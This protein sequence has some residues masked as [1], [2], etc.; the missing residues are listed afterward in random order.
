MP[1][2]VLSFLLDNAVASAA[3]SD[4]ESSASTTAGRINFKIIR[5]DLIMKL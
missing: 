5:I 3:D 2:K 4:T 1:N